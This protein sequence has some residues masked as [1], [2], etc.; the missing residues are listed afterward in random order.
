MYKMKTM[1]LLGVY[2]IIKVFD[3]LLV[4][5]GLIAAIIVINALIKSNKRKEK[6]VNVP[7]LKEPPIN[8]SAAK[9]AFLQNI[10]SFLPKLNS[11]YDSSYNS[12]DWTDAIIDT[13][14]DDLIRLWKK[15]N[16]DT[17]AILRVFASWGLTPDLCTSF[18]CLQMHQEQYVKTDGS[19]LIVGQKY[20]VVK[21]CWIIVLKNN[22]DKFVKQVLL[23]GQVA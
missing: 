12:S 14:N 19:P 11:L 13:N 10:R 22:E 2:A 7:K 15:I 21:P 23:K 1:D 8:Q 5:A 17:S 20:S 16:S 9:L 4:I 3:I 6:K 18:I